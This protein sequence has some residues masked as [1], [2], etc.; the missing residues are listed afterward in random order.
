[1]QI[2]LLREAG[3]VILAHTAMALSAIAIGAAVFIRRKG[4]RVHR[5]M[6][7]L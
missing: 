3:P 7:R 2:A 1:M 5:W 6:G 4:T